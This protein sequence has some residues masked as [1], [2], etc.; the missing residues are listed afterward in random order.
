MT[1][2]RVSRECVEQLHT[3]VIAHCAEALEEPEFLP[4]LVAIVKLEAD[5]A[6]RYERARVLGQI[7]KAGNQ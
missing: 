1:E 2:R 5:K 7:R 6:Q 4:G 3:W